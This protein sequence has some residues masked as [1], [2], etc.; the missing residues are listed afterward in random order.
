MVAMTTP[1]LAPPLSP[2]LGVKHAAVPWGSPTHGGFRQLACGEGGLTPPTPLPAGVIAW[3]Q[4]LEDGDAG[5]YAG[6]SC[7][8]PGV[9]S[10]CEVLGA[11][12]G[13][14]LPSEGPHP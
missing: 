9:T 6:G 7:M 8:S 10:K 4:R 2:H 1:G 14:Y 11:S 13:L 5:S 12:E 3:I